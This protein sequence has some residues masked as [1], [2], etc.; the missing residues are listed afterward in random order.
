MES[1]CKLRL[2]SW[3]ARVPTHSN[4]SDGPSRMDCTEIEQLG[5]VEAKVDWNYVLE[6]LL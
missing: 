4:I 2:K 5:S 3:Y 1:E 6:N